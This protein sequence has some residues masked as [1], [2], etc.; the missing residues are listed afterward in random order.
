MLIFLDY[1]S[2]INPLNPGFTSW[3]WNLPQYWSGAVSLHVMTMTTTTTTKTR[4]SLTTFQR[5][6]NV[7]RAGQYVEGNQILM[8]IDR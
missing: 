4:T 2:S 5:K 1:V 8:V 3:V 7:L 6:R